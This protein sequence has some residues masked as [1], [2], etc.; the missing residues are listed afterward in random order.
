MGSAP[1]L[2]LTWVALQIKVGKRGGVTHPGFASK[3]LPLA[4]IRALLVELASFGLLQRVVL[5]KILYTMN[6]KQSHNI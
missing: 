1:F 3:A 6:M 5:P 2:F 4:R